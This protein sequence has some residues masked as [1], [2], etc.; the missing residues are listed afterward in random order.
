MPIRVT[1][2]PHTR[3]GLI[4]RYKGPR[5]GVLLVIL[6]WFGSDLFLG[7]WSLP[8]MSFVIERNKRNNFTF[9]QNV[10]SR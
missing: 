9:D 2:L 1:G 7:C 10:S 5:A 3:R 6:R 4:G 8:T